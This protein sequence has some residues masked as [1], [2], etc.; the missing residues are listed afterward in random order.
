MNVEKN[1]FQ[2]NFHKTKKDYWYY[3]IKGLLAIIDGLV[4]VFSFGSIWSSFE[5]EYTK[6]NLFKE[7][8]KK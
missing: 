8:I 6:N 7:K 4:S 2:V 5:Y 1:W 3:F